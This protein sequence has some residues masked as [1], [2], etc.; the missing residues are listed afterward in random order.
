MLDTAAPIQIYRHQSYTYDRYTHQS[1]YTSEPYTEVHGSGSQVRAGGTW[2]DIAAKD[3][4]LGINKFWLERCTVYTVLL[5]ASLD[6][7]H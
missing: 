6:S 7:H 4:G 5:G 3:N 2:P 1:Y